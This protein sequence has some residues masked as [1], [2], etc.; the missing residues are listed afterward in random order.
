MARM[1]TATLDFKAFWDAYGLKRNRREAEQVW[2]SLPASAR[3]DAIAGIGAYQAARRKEDRPVEYAQK[4][5]SRRLWEKS[6]A[7]RADAG[8]VLPFGM[9]VW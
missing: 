9:E 4:Y 7:R 2:E 1:R 5:L 3:R 8:S 6:H